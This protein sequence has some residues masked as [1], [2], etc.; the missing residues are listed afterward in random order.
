MYLYSDRKVIGFV[1]HLESRVS[2][3]VPFFVYPTF[4]PWP[5]FTKPPDAQTLPSVVQGE[6]KIL[7]KV[8]R[9]LMPALQAAPSSNCVMRNLTGMTHP[10]I[11]GI[12][13]IL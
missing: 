4:E 1:V 9:Q 5:M 13:S 7:G 10:L 11:V 12:A 6:G 3:L 8:V 2:A